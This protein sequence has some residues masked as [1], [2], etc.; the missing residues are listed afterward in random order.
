M[1]KYTNIS[2]KIYVGAYLHVLVDFLCLSFCRIMNWAKQVA[3][4]VQVARGVVG[5]LQD[6]R[7]AGLHGL[8]KRELEKIGLFFAEKELNFPLSLTVALDKK[9]TK[10]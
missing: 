1:L 3:R 7:E 4:D 5:V 6:D 9:I 8:L 10:S 2:S